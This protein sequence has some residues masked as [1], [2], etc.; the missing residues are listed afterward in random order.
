VVPFRFTRSYSGRCVRRRVLGKENEL[1]FV[2]YVAT[3]FVYLETSCRK[4]Q[5]RFA[6]ERSVQKKSSPENRGRLLKKSQRYCPGDCAGDSA[7]VSSVPAAASG[8]PAGASVAAGLVT[9]VVAGGGVV[10]AGVVAGATVS[11][12]C[13]HAARSAAPASMQ[14]YFFIIRNAYC[15]IRSI[16]ASAVFGPH[17]MPLE[18]QMAR[19]ER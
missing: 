10:G 14:M 15:F 3:T 9:S 17:R 2:V 12:F 4:M 16:A 11:V 8:L 1:T 7:G 18:T 13:S 5:P 19:H 6:I